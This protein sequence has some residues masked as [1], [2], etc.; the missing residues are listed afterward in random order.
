MGSV[1][2][3][4]AGDWR[5]SPDAGASV[6]RVFWLVTHWVTRLP[7]RAE[8]V[9]LVEVVG[10]RLPQM[11]SYRI[12]Q[13]DATVV[14]ELADIGDKQEELLEAFDECRSG[15]CSCPTN[16]YEKLAA[17]D[18]EASSEQITLRLQTKPGTA[19][20]SSELA[21]CLDHTVAKLGGE[22]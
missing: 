2:A 16:E 15:R 20:D 22:R 13:D 18:V 19:F 8:G 10:V 12:E 17:M 6:R 3:A 21:A 11:A 4:H 1:V 7:L 14:I 5:V 9:G